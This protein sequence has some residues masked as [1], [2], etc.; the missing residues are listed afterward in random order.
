MLLI[1]GGTIVIL[2]SFCL[3]LGTSLYI[4]FLFLWQFVFP[5]SDTAA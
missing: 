1:L 3:P 2:H 5:F 4:A